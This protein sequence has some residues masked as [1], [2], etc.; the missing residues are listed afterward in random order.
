MALLAPL[1][2]AQDFGEPLLKSYVVIDA[3]APLS[4]EERHAM[5]FQQFDVVEGLG[6][7]RAEVR[8]GIEDWLAAR[9]L[10]ATTSDVQGQLVTVTVEF[11]NPVRG[12]LYIDYEFRPQKRLAALEFTFLAP[13]RLTAVQK[14]QLVARHGLVQLKQA[15]SA[16]MKCAGSF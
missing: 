5:A 4:D 3:D 6:D 9:N 10:V 16:Q 15:L 8:Q 2:F 14:Q 7:C 13:T 1:A 11:D 12:T